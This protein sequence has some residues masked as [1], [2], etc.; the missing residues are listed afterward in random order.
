MGYDDT[1]SR[2]RTKAA[3]AL[4]TVNQLMARQGRLIETVA[5]EEL[6]TRRARLEVYQT[7]ARYAVADSYDR[8]AK[9]QGVSAESATSATGA[10]GAR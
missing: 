10:G 7:Q 9:A 3:E 8:A 2:L 5:I 4:H 1:I 6:K